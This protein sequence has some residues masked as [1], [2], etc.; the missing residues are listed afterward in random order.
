[1]LD[2]DPFKRPNVN[3]ILATRKVQKILARRRL[4]TPIKVAK[5]WSK[6]VWSTFYVIRAF[7]LNVI[8]MISSA[9]KIKRLKS[10]YRKDL[11]AH[12][13]PRQME[14]SSDDSFLQLEDSKID[15]EDSPS[16]RSHNSTFTKTS[17][18]QIANSTPLNHYNTQGTFRR[19]RLELSRTSLK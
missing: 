2:P 3:T 7:I 5:K 13:T 15:F 6:N 16:N 12:S 11:T 9:L 17:D 10:G 18:A 19:S 1:M 4:M 8:S 14:D